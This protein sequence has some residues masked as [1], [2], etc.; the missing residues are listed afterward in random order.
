MSD[1]QTA[2]PVL[3]REGFGLIDAGA[4]E[5]LPD[6]FREIAPLL[7]AVG[8]EP[9]AEEC[10]RLNRAG[11]SG[12]AFGKT[13]YLPWALGAREG[14]ADFHV[15]RSKGASS[16]Y[17]PNRAWL[18]RFPDPGRYDVVQTRTVPVRTLDGIL[19]E[20]GPEM[21]G[22]VDFLKLDVQGAELD[23]LKGAER[24]LAEQAIGVEVEVEFFQLYESQPLFRDVDAFLSE[25][26]F[27]LFKLRRKSWVRANCLEK[28]QI[29]AGQLV[30]AD[31]LYLRDPL[32]HGWNPAGP[33]AA[34]RL[35]ALVLAAA[36]YDL[37]DFALEITADETIRA[38]IE[39]RSNRLDYQPN[40][41][42]RLASWMKIAGEIRKGKPG[43]GNLYEWSRRRSWG[44]A[45]SDK[46]FYTRTR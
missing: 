5:G 19:Q 45:D 18:N 26:G 31:A 46:D 2:F 14:Q 27:T 22:P 38:W 7:K 32:Q 15:C 25:R 8:F 28:P 39:K 10:G 9:D 12:T 23:V 41:S 17:A 6:L 40:G 16:F 36:L 43:W 1:L 24:V 33:A 44:R 4:R 21:P 35:E 29:S 34:H 11:P 37:N 13:H 20:A 30:A 3:T 42:G